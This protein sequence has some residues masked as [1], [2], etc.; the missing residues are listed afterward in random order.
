MIYR[1]ATNEAETTTT[2]M[3]D[4]EIIASPGMAN[5]D[6]FSGKKESIMGGSAPSFSVLI[7]DPF[8]DDRDDV[9]LKLHELI[10][11]LQL[12][13]DDDGKLDSLEEVFHPN[14]VKPSGYWSM[15]ICLTGDRRYCRKKKWLMQKKGLENVHI[16]EHPASVR[17]LPRAERLEIVTKIC[18][19]LAFLHSSEKQVI[20]RD[21]KAP[22]ILLDETFKCNL[23]DFSTAK[24]SAVEN[25]DLTALD[26]SSVSA[27]S[28]KTGM[29]MKMAQLESG[30]WTAHD[31]AEKAFQWPYK[32]SHLKNTRPNL[33]TENE[34]W[35]N[36]LYLLLIAT[37]LST[38]TFLS[39]LKIIGCKSEEGYKNNSSLNPICQ[40]VNQHPFYIQ[41]ITT[42][43]SVAFFLS[44]ALMMIL[45]NKL[46]LR[47]LLLVSAFSMLGA[48]MCIISGPTKAHLS[49][50]YST[51]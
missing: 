48:Y 50:F 1:D 14:Q 39:A 4:D 19:D 38:I 34:T 44:I 30:G 29:E 24:V 20:Y 11:P 36:F 5:S 3:V 33:K 45:F 10:T 23:S 7:H 47:P 43:N 17:Q 15:N 46:P 9:M 26:T 6:L 13:R 51:F 12:R 28:G 2:A 49:S 16:G 42:F 32:S 31:E 18:Q 22:N 25:A 37:L 41:L 35:N 8:P 40:I 21:I 27:Q